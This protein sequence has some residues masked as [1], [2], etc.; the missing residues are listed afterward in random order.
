M[1]TTGS[2]GIP[3]SPAG[4]SAVSRLAWV[5]IIVLAI[6]GLALLPA[7][8]GSAAARLWLVALWALAL[9]TSLAVTVGRRLA[10]A[11][12]RPSTS[13]L[14][15][16]ALVAGLLAVL[17]NADGRAGLR[18]ASGQALAQGSSGRP[19]AVDAARP[20]GATSELEIRRQRLLS[21]GK[22][23]ATSKTQLR[24][25]SARP[26]MTDKVAK[27]IEGMK[28]AKPVVGRPSVISSRS[29]APPNAAAAPGTIDSLLAT[30]V[31]PGFE[32]GLAGWVV[33]GSASSVEALT[34]ADM[35][36]VA[37]TE[38]VQ[39]ALL[40]NGP[41]AQS[42]GG[43]GN[44]D[45][46]AGGNSDS[47]RSILAQSFTLTAA[48][49]PAR[50][51]FDWNWVTDEDLTPGNFDDFF[52]VTLNGSP[53]LN[54]SVANGGVSPFPD[55]IT[56]GIPLSVA[57]GGATN[58]CTFS[59][60]QSNFQTFSMIVTNPGP[61]TLQFLVADQSD[62]AN[63]SGLVV[64]NVVVT[65]DID[66]AVTKTATPNP[67]IA[68]ETMIWHVAVTNR[69]TGRASSVVV[70]DT[71]PSP[72]ALY[73]SDTQGCDVSALPVIVCQLGDILP[74]QTKTFDVSMYVNADTVSNGA[75]RTL[76][77]VAEAS[78]A[79]FDPLLDNNIFTRTV[80]VNDLANLRITKIG[81]PDLAVR[82]GGELN[83]TVYV[84]NLGPST[85][86]TVTVTDTMVSNL[87]FSLLSLP[88][89]CTSVPAAPGPA[90]RFDL[91][92]TRDTLDGTAPGE[93][94]TLDYVVSSND[95]SSI[96]NIASVRAVT[97]DPVM[98]NNFALT[99]HEVTDTAD[100]NITK[101]GTALDDGSFIVVAGRSVVYDI[102]VT[103][104]G[105][106]TAE[107]VTVYDNLPRGIVENSLQ[108][109]F[110]TSDGG[111]GICTNGTP[112]DPSDP[113]ICQIGNLTNGATASI[114]IIGDVDPNFVVDTVQ[115]DFSDFLANDA[116]VTS[117]IFDPDTED[118]RTSEIFV[119]VIGIADLDITKGALP[120]GTLAGDLQGFEID[121]TNFGPSTAEDV[122][123]VDLLPEGVT[124]VSAE[125]VNDGPEATCVSYPGAG[126]VICNLGDI[127]PYDPILGFPRR[128]VFITVRINP[129]VPTQVIT[130]TALS[131][132]LAT[133]DPDF[134]NNE[135]SVAVT[136]N[137]TANMTITKVASTQAPVAGE[138]FHYTITVL[139]T[140]PS[141]AHSVYIT[142]ILPSNV[143]Y[144]YDT[145]NCGE[146][147]LAAG[148][149]FGDLDP[150][151]GRDGGVITFDVYV[152]L[153]ADAD[154]DGV[155]TNTATVGWLDGRDTV[156]MPQSLSRTTTVPIDCASD[157]RV[158]KFGKPDGSV[159]AGEVLTYT[160]IV[161][162]LGP[163][164]PTTVT[165][166]DVMQSSGVF[167]L[168]SLTSD[169][170]ATCTF[171]AGGPA[172]PPPITNINQR[173]LTDCS[174]DDPLEVLGPGGLPVNP[175]RWIVT[176]TVTAAQLQTI[177]N[178][179]TVL[180]NGVDSDQT[181]NEAIAEHAIQDIADLQV[182][183]TDSPDPVIAGTALTYTI[184]ITNNGPSD[185]ENVDL[186]DRLPSGIVVTGYS[187]SNG[188]TCSTGTAGS[189][190]D[191]LTCGLGTI[192]SVGPVTTVVVTVN[193]TVNPDIPNGTILEND[194]LVTA[195]T[196]DPYSGNDYEAE[197]TTVGRLANIRLT[198]G[199]LP[200]I[201]IAG[202]P[203]SFEIDVTNLGPSQADDVFVTDFL[204]LGL[205]FV[206]AYAVNDGAEQTCI[207]YAGP[208][209]VVCNLGDIPPVDPVLGAPQRF[210]F[211]NTIVDADTPPSI[212]TN[213]ATG[214]SLI[215][216][217]PDF[218][219]NTPSVTVTVITEAD[220][221]V[222]KTSDPATVFAGEQKRYHIKV[223]N[224][225][226]S[227][228]QDV[229]LGDVLP[230]EALYKLDTGLCA[231]AGSVVQCALGTI[232]AG[233][234]K[235]IDIYVEI[236]PATVIDLTIDPEGATI[237]N[238]AVALSSP[239]SPPNA[240]FDPNLANNTSLREN[241][242]EE[243]ADL[244]VTKFGK[245]DGAARA[246]DILTYTIIVDNLG[247]S[248]AYSVTLKDVLQSS[249]NFDV[250][251]VISDRAATC[252]SIP[253]GGAGYV[254]PPVAWPPAAPPPAFGVN[255][256]SGVA[257]VAQRYELDCTL[258]SPLAVLSPVGGPQNPGRW[259]VTMR[260]R[261][262]QPQTINNVATVQSDI[263]SDPATDNNEATVEHE[264]TAV[265]DLQVTK[266][267]FPDPVVAGTPLT[268]TI[269]VTN[270]GPSDAENVVL[271]DR[272][273][274]GIVVT[275]FTV[276]NGAT[277]STGAPGS[278]QDQ[279]TCGLGFLRAVGPVT[280]VVITVSMDVN[281]D[282]PEG[283]I[284]E[285]DVYVTSDV[286]DDN[287]LNNWAHQLT[288]VGTV[289]NLRIQK[290]GNPGPVPAGTQ[291][292]YD[293][294]YQNLGPSVAR[295]V[296]ILDVLP[297]GFDILS[298]Q[299]VDGP[300]VAGQN[301]CHLRS[302]DPALVDSF[303]CE[304]GDMDPGE[305]GN[306]VVQVFV[307]ANEPAGPHINT[308]SIT[309]DTFDPALGNNTATFTT[310]VVTVADMQVEKTSAPQVVYA[311]EQKL[312]TIKITNNG[313]STRRTSSS[314]TRCRSR[315]S[316]R[317]TPPSATS[318]AASSRAAS[319]PCRWARAA[320]SR[321]GR[322]LIRRRSRT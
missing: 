232:A 131:L 75:P 28:A 9:A 251:D 176:M 161:D 80:V 101:I 30:P 289:A 295:D 97:P 298:V 190:I 129:D 44:L 155:V 216:A 197:L 43:E 202:E 240:T 71:L 183:K 85:A 35:P 199:A 94:W 268:Y 42:G 19:A 280:T 165:L 271:Y 281:D 163:S 62:V 204:P 146:A 241:F 135:A 164:E 192:R 221:L 38:G 278:V 10:P 322:K 248:Y 92:C 81:K 122:L 287:N 307:R 180:S 266:T 106:S 205:T 215:T 206:N 302:G 159:R 273:P 218:S 132:S 126:E 17:G 267:D 100:L 265:A 76:T 95:T 51:S 69:G 312:Y 124:F 149:S 142:D 120:Q 117:D 66:L 290:F 187:T 258:A 18:P 72:E 33:G 125:V 191:K 288:T 243:K 52:Q 276:S 262:R 314:P 123:L 229:V 47:D 98:A 203:L 308:V 253:P 99:E 86:T 162:N 40:C 227:D 233:A 96:N 194:V 138:D 169:R 275:G 115:T 8:A 185:A 209:E 139:N 110:S 294:R 210:I 116:F 49:V 89:E 178:V 147:T 259:I 171:D 170:A 174:L 157:L 228:A 256:P 313:P 182:T 1:N 32:A 152:R 223:T 270:N 300:G 39:M 198:K 250:I 284:L 77:N 156:A 109:L 254:L 68:G 188:A 306:L 230:P 285:N 207:Y 173:L 225:G 107:N 20:K 108:A 58:G 4:P 143:T 25:P 12:V 7:W 245:K 304:V 37:P 6:A 299:V 70:T 167:T 114:Q 211:I 179:A 166:K 26:V 64:D 283:T 59:F 145:A 78:A 269:I 119:E 133:I 130:N 90:T 168:L 219:N 292:S 213:N 291:T 16:V 255:P 11:V 231:H 103:N 315:P 60:G 246:G 220:L 144:L 15:P 212:I 282:V 21:A 141:T 24:D 83:Y 73:L 263:A 235:E 319:A 301:T 13:R 45:N 305:I 310:N 222:E 88:A 22:T 118:N 2:N 46:D 134:S 296:I 208:R 34:S 226:P 260:I 177:N 293:I 181:N 316:T 172:G 63:D 148:C 113:L 151:I 239:S 84:D 153:N 249:G 23:I 111:S 277:C 200:M 137:T 91:T 186:L 236:D 128:F 31:N 217:D 193:A 48:E 309:S 3:Q 105:P 274:P 121:I 184:R 201:V 158:R 279:F 237:T 214:L 29:A 242:V 79:N 5:A 53:I 189:A 320:S 196:Y 224:L 50:L 195:D 112:G 244:K 252:R 286:F 317:S 247:P 257:D 65:P 272:L 160:L 56:D 104:N 14:V 54:G 238:S 140:G 303:T 41:G 55:V 67:A 57:S 321:S 150:R 234:S 74:G 136:V 297:P 93:R 61:Y 127:E 27:A 36:G 175:G 87:P 82:A 102:L 261:A 311:G 154:C 264:I 318:R